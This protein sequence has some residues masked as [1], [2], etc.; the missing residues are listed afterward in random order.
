MDSEHQLAINLSEAYLL[1][2][3]KNERLRKQKLDL[4]IL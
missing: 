2:E 3:S 1:A 4:A